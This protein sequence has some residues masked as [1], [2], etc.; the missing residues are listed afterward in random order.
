MGKTEKFK[1]HGHIDKK[2]IQKFREGSFENAD[3]IV[4][5]KFNFVARKLVPLAAEGK[6]RKVTLHKFMSMQEVTDPSD[7]ALV[8]WVLDTSMDKWRRTESNA[9]GSSTN[10]SK[11]KKGGDT[12]TKEEGKEHLSTSEEGMKVFSEYDTKISAARKENTSWDEAVKAKAAEEDGNERNSVGKRGSEE[13]I[14]QKGTKKVRTL[15]EVRS[16]PV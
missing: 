4:Q 5:E 9:A 14:E 10:R 1:E 13:G 11:T 6:W 7:E 12:K 15:L 8:Y 2:S 3:K 16:V